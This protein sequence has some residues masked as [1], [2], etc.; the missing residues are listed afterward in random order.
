[1]TA[2]RAQD[3]TRWLPLPAAEVRFGHSALYDP[4]ASRMPVMVGSASFFAPGDALVLDL[5]S[6]TWFDL[7]TTG[8]KPRP[9]TGTGPVR[10]SGMALDAEERVAL[11]TCDCADASTYLFD[12]AEG[13][14]SVAPRDASLRVVG[15]STTYDPVADRMLVVGGREYGIGPVLNTAH[16][17]DMS[18]DRTGWQPVAAA[19]FALADASS[20]FVEHVN[21]MLVFGGQDDEG[22]FSRALW[23]LDADADG[24]VGAWRDLTELAGPGPS[25]RVGASFVYVDELQVVLLYGG[26]APGQD[27]NDVWVLDYAAAD[28]PSWT[29]LTQADGGPGSRA[30]HSAVWDALARRLVV[31]GGTRGEG[32]AVELLGDAW[33][34]PVEALTPEP[35]PSPSPDPTSAPGPHMK[36][37]LPALV[38][39]AGP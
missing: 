30:A 26:Y 2:V 5:T 35:V 23:R 6:D 33:S 12:L 31:Y 39:G 29:R 37:F 38:R 27:N 1:V 28:R 24:G 14:W 22:S 34:L 4:V 3:E 25:G 8:Q 19:P 32:G 10:G 9:R 21:H 18:V 13:A 11:L 20:A 7:S 17:Y 15:G 16:A 36:V